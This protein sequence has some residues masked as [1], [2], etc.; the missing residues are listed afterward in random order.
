MDSHPTGGSRVR[1]CGGVIAAM[2]AIL[3]RVDAAA[4]ATASI[5][6]PVELVHYLRAGDERA[7]G[8]Q[9][10]DQVGRSLDRLV[11]HTPSRM[12]SCGSSRNFTTSFMNRAAF[13]P[14]T[15]R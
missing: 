14:S 7:L 15:T 9:D 2:T 4:L 8:V 13:A 5:Q 10:R 1:C 11:G 3:S 6:S 12:N